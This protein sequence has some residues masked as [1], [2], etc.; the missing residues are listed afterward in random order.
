[1]LNTYAF[2]FRDFELRCYIVDVDDMITVLSNL[3]YAIVKTLRENGIEIP[4]PQQDVH[5]KGLDKLQE[6]V[7]SATRPDPSPKSSGSS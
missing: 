6:A 5:F 3:R 1:M 4:F 7:A 2:Y